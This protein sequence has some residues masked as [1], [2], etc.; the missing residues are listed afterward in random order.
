MSKAYPVNSD[1]RA[2]MM[3]SL[4][5]FLLL[6]LVNCT[7]WAGSVELRPGD[8]QIEVLIDGRAFTT[9]YFDPVMAKPFHSRRSG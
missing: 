3:R 8:K 2:T 1:E 4:A 6:W 5:L 7:S 9:Y